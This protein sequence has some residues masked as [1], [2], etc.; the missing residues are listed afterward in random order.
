M[1]IM[2]KFSARATFSLRFGIV[3]LFFSGIISTPQAY[4]QFR[5]DVYTQEVLEATAVELSARLP[6][7]KI[8][9]GSEA[10]LRI[11]IKNNYSQIIKCLIDRYDAFGGFSVE[12]KN[13]KGEIVKPSK[14]L[15]PSNGIS[16]LMSAEYGPQTE[17][18]ETLLLSDYYDFP[19]GE[20][21]VTVS[22]E[23]YVFNKPKT[24]KRKIFTATTSFTVTK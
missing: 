5:P 19:K 24:V 1:N 4:A 15:R 16:S 2:N 17:N 18:E 11:K 21:I 22:A 23:F 20:Y 12:I 14:E 7:S 6:K 8:H 9:L 13:K 3:L 10:R